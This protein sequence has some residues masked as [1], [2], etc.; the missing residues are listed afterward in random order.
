MKRLFL[1]YMVV[2]QAACGASAV[3]VEA[4]AGTSLE[5]TEAALTRCGIGTCLEGEFSPGYGCSSTC[6]TGC[7]TSS[8][9]R[10]STYCYPIPKGTG[11]GEWF[12][13]CGIDPMPPPPGFQVYRYY[14]RAGCEL[15]GDDLTQN[16]ATTYISR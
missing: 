13:A 2:L 4:E 10:N 5:T 7:S 9:Y 6:G 3:S 15:P 8:P 16:N 14:H 1:T 12:D 11:S